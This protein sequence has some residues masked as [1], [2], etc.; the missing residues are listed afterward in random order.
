MPPAQAW[1]GVSNAD[2][3][4]GASFA[5]TQ[6]Y[7]RVHRALVLPWLDHPTMRRGTFEASNHPA[8]F[9]LATDP[10]LLHLSNFASFSAT[11]GGSPQGEDSGANQERDGYRDGWPQ[12]HG[13]ISPHG[14]QREHAAGLWKST[15]WP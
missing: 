8:C 1:L 9:L 12:E 11:G 4:A 15:I 5:Q 14:A 7:T 3:T 13:H 10:D 6:N 2:P